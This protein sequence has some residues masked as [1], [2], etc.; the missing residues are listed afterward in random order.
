MREAR[1]PKPLV[2]DTSVAV[3]WYLPE[4]LREEA[5]E[6]AARMGA[7]E[8]ELFAPSTIGPELF[9]ALFQQHRRGYLSLDEVREFF[10]SFAEAPISVFEIDPLTPR[11]VEIAVGSGVIVYDALFMALAEDTGTVMATADGRLLRSLEGTS[12][13]HL[14]YSLSNIGSLLP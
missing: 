11:A 8:V 10:S 9:N 6:L 12:F 3:K 14:V 13:A 5:L 2:L 4:D 1:V 7:G